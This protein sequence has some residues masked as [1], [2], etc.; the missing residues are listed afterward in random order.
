MK[1]KQE[2]KTRYILYKNGVMVGESS[3]KIG[4]ANMIGCTIDW[5]YKAIDDQGNLPFQKNNY[6]MV[7]KLS[8]I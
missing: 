6:R 3:N 7:D 8:L 2:K 1:T 5:V 4:I